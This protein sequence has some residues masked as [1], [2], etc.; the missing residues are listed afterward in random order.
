MREVVAR[1]GNQPLGY[2]IL[3]GLAFGRL[4]HRG[5]GVKRYR[6]AVETVGGHSWVDYGS[7]SAVHE[8]A[9]LV[10][11]LAKIRLPKR[12]RTTMNVGRIAGGVSI[13]TIAPSAWIEVDL[14]SED[15]KTLEHIC[16]KVESAVKAAERRDVSYKHEQIGYREFGEIPVDHPLVLLGMDA[17]R[18][19]GVEPDLLIGSTDANIPLSKGIPAICIGLASGGAAHTVH[20]FMLVENLPRGLAQLLEI[21]TESFQKLAS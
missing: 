16:T 20:E 13:N 14:R 18:R 5:L 11:D 9:G 4:Y 21:V 1:F 10:A 8:L 3:E 6:I 7:P 12:P 19:Q 2:V 17:L 15:G